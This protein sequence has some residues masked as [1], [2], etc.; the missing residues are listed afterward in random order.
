MRFMDQPVAANTAPSPADLRPDEAVVALVHCIVRA[1][2]GRK[3]DNIC[4]YHVHHLTSLTSAL[5]CVSGNSRP[6]N[7]AICAAVSA[8]VAADQLGPPV[9][10]EG[11]AESGW[12]LLDYGS[13]MVHVMTPKSRLF[14]NVEGQWKDKN[15]VPMDVSAILVPNTMVAADAPPPVA[16]EE[17]D[18]FWS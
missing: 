12:M 11:T 9:S 5:V 13:V 16:A 10:V 4:A 8:A 14:Y 17:L 1:A 2:D 3:A 7:Q 15:A 18:P 6:Q